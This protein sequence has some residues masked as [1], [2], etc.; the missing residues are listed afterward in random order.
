MPDLRRE[1]PQ[2]KILLMSADDRAVVLQRARQAG[3]E[4]CV[5]KARLGTDLL[6]AITRFS[7]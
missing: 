6:P 4:G 3:A 1:L 2:T 7:A 5:D